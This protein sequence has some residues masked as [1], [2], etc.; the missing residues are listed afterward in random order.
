VRGITDLDLTD[1]LAGQELGF[2]CKLLAVAHQHADGLD[3]S[4]QPTFIRTTHPLAGVAGP[5]NAVSVYG[6]AVGHCLF[7][8]RGAGGRP[9][10]S[11][12]V[13][14]LIDVAIGNARRAF[15]TLAMNGDAEPPRYR[16]P[17][18]NVSP[19]YL[20][21]RLLDQPGGMGQLATALG[22]AGV[23]I[24]SLVQHEPQA[25][26]RDGAVP[27][28]ATTH[29][30]REAHIRQAVDAVSKLEVVRGPTVC[31]PVLAEH[32]EATSA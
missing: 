18:D 28:V 15:E 9:T 10:A 17:G 11:A 32:D 14:D 29:P 5:F 4:V 31:I 16:D 30:A 8:G 25:D 20:R 12:V 22:N 7:Y 26:H 23:S 13:A 3:L 24:A 2:V 27:V 1:L 19:W 21:V 6:D